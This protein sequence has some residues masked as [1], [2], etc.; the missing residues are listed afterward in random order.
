MAEPTDGNTSKTPAVSQGAILMAW[1]DAATE[2]RPV[3]RNSSGS[4]K[5]EAVVST[6]DAPTTGTI[7]SVNDAA[8][9]TT[10]LASNANRK[11]ATIYND[12]PSVLYLALASVTSS[13]TN[14]SVQLA[15]YDYYELPVCDGGVYTGIIKGIWSANASGAARVTELT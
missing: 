9:D 15:A 14:Y 4:L 12:S 6:G 8:S 13:T 5:T 1:D 7:T 2:F 3:Y 10:I 11:G